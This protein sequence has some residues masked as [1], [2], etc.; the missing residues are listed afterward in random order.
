MER[1]RDY[2]GLLERLELIAKWITMEE[3]QA[4]E[5]KERLV[6]R[7]LRAILKY[8]YSR[9]MGRAR[10]Q[11]G[12]DSD[13]SVPGIRAYEYYRARAERD[14]EALLEACPRGRLD[15]RRIHESRAPASEGFEYFRHLDDLRE[16][17][18]RL[19]RVRR[20]RRY[21]RLRIR[22]KVV[23]EMDTD[24]YLSR[25]EGP[26]HCNKVYCVPCNAE[27]AQS[28][29]PFHVKG[30]KHARN[31]E[32]R[33]TVLFLGI[34]AD[35]ARE[36]IGKMIKELGTRK[37]QVPPSD[38]APRWLLRQRGMEVTFGCEICGYSG[39]GRRPF[40]DHFNGVEHISALGE[41]GVCDSDRVKGITRIGALLK[42]CGGREDEGF[43]EEFED[44]EGNVYDRRTYEDLKRNNLL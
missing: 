39:R 38:G 27:I 36:E 42:L 1:L 16:Y 31:A 29:F 33:S 19:I 28:V 20:Y 8:K 24:A 34:P 3:T 18:I 11:V 37:Q 17:L 30:R 15:A 9:A 44:N 26:T 5:G 22:G 23:R 2:I 7:H 25:E 35:R 4:M 21:R 40:E 13:I 14:V 43:E 10:K 12:A 6:S 41:Y 32:G